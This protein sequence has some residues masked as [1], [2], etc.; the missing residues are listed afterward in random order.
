MRE[1]KDPPS[2]QISVTT[3]SIL[4]LTLRPSVPS[5][6]NKTL[7]NLTPSTGSGL[8]PVLAKIQIQIFVP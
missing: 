4:R 8:T 2:A 1:N 3:T 6:V 5:F 7:R